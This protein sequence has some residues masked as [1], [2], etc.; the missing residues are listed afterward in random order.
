MKLASNFAAAAPLAMQLR[1]EIFHVRR[2]V[3][4]TAIINACR[5]LAALANHAFIVL[6]H[7]RF[8]WIW[9]VAKIRQGF[10]LF[11][12]LHRFA[13]GFGALYHVRVAVCAVLLQITELFELLSVLRIANFAE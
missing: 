12:R 2:A 13:C 10:W 6:K 11:I 5:L 7:T 8:K 9:V 3:N 4:A 1:A